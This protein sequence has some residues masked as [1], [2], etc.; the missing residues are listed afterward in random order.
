MKIMSNYLFCYFTGNRPEEESVHFAVSKDGY[1]FEALNENKPVIHQTKGKKSSRDPFIFRDKDNVFHIIAT[2]MRCHDGW[3]SNNSMVMWDSK[4]L[5]NWENERIFD[6]SQFENTKNADRVWAPQVIYDDDKNEYMIYW[7]HS[8]KDDELPTILWYI[9]TKDFKSFTTKPKVLFKP[10]G[11]LAGIDGDIVKKDNKYYLYYADEKKDGICCAVSHKASGPYEE[12]ENN[13]VSVANTKVEGNC[14][15]KISGTQ[16]YVMIMDK[17]VEGGYFMQETEDMFNFK[18]VDDNRFKINH[19]HP[20]H[21]S[22]LHITEE[23]YCKL[24]KHFNN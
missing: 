16:K 14:I 17:F 22:V 10:K 4:D 23:E 13:K 2:D 9:Y 5:I 20:R 12:F 8:N 11:N 24:K 3:N 18:K 1:N 21:G 6:F 7:S 19:L 15:Y